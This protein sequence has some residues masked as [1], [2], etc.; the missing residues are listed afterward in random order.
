MSLWA[1]MPGRSRSVGSPFLARRF[2][3]LQMRTPGKL[4]PLGTTRMSRKTSG[5]DIHNLCCGSPSGLG[6][7]SLCCGSSSV[8]RPAHLARKQRPC[9]IKLRSIGI[10]AL[11]LAGGLL[12]TCWVQPFRGNQAYSSRKVTSM[13]AET[14]TAWPCRI[15]G[16]KRHCITASMAFSSNPRPSGWRILTSRTEPSF[17]TTRLSTT[18]P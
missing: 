1:E 3:V 9:W 8:L 16:L 13:M 2:V 17:W 15:P 10:Q 4:L 12:E 14:S 18:V 7:E 11:Q 6:T 5:A